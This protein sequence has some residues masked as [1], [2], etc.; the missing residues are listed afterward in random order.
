MRDFD[1]D[2]VYLCNNPIVLDSKI[3]KTIV[4]DIED[5]ATSQSLGYDIENIATYELNSRDSR[6]GEITNVAMSIINQYTEDEEWQKINSDNVSL[7]R[8]FQ[9][10]FAP[11]CSNAIVKQLVNLEI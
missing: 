1:G 6:I 2:S 10:E 3:D 9:G 8:L 4:V 5:K 11:R 7:L